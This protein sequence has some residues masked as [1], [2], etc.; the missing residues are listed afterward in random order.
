[1]VKSIVESTGGKIWFTSE[2]GK[3]TSFVI[4]LKEY[5]D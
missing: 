2:V 5:N 4:A 3:G 1:M